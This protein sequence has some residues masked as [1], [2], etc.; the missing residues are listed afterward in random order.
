MMILMFVVVIIIQ[1]TKD[2]LESDYIK[3]RLAGRKAEEELQKSPSELALFVQN[4]FVR[5]Y[6]KCDRNPGMHRKESIGSGKR[7]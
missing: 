4:L 7:S 1:H 6:R 3:H 2:L 5:G